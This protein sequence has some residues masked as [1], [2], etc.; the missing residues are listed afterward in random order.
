MTEEAENDVGTVGGAASVNPTTSTLASLLRNY[1]YID[2]QLSP[3]SCPDAAD[4][5]CLDSG[6]CVPSLARCNMLLECSDGSDEDECSCADRLRAQFLERK[7]CDG[8]VDCHDSSDEQFCDWCG[9]GKFICPGAKKCVDTSAICDGQL[10]CADGADERQ[11]VTLSTARSAAGQARYQPAGYLM[12]RQRGHWGPLCVDDFDALVRRTRTAWSV[13][14]LGSAVCTALTYRDATHVFRTESEPSVEQDQPEPFYKLVLS[15]DGPRSDTENTSLVFE[16]ASCPRRTAV[17]ISCGDLQCGLRPRAQQQRARIVGGTNT[18]PGAWPWQAAM[19]RE[20]EYQCGATLI[21]DRWLLSAGHCFLRSTNSHWVARL[22][23]YR[24]GS[25]LLSPYESLHI[26]SHIVVHPEY[27]DIGY[28]NDIALLK[29]EDTARMSDFVRPV[30]LPPAGADVTEGALC[31]VIGWGQLFEA[32]R[33]FPDT[34]Q[35]VELPLISTQQCK[36]RTAFL[37]LYRITDNMFCAGFDRGGRDACLGDSGGPLMC[38]V[39]VS[40]L[41]ESGELLIC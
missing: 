5:Q 15:P 7:V 29:L 11:C 10:D 20:G 1:T 41:G 30:C 34:L 9:P 6:E 23:A 32:G 36:K 18:S 24:R 13:R 35:E 3:P 40:C 22:G 31:S 39:G 21:S 17:H 27:Q 25:T 4:F 33:I 19:Y 28:V 37:P 38:Q 8:I 16:E 14:E 26:V 12:V 2:S